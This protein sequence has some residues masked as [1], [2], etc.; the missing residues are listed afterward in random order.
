MTVT[1]F[2]PFLRE[3]SFD[4]LFLPGFSNVMSLSHKNVARS[5]S[6]FSSS[7]PYALINKMNVKIAAD[8]PGYDYMLKPRSLHE[9]SRDELDLRK[10]LNVLRE[11]TK[12]AL[13][14]AWGE[15]TEKEDRIMTLERQIQDLLKREASYKQHL[16]EASQQAR[17]GSCQS[18]ARSSSVSRSIAERPRANSVN[19]TGMLDK[20]LEKPSKQRRPSG[21]GSV[22]GWS[23]GT[24]LR[25]YI[26]GKKGNTKM[27]KN[28][29]TQHL[30]VL[31]KQKRVELQEY[32]MKLQNKDTAIR[33]LEQAN[34]RHQHSIRSLQL[35]LEQANLKHQQTVLSLQMELER[36]KQTAIE[37]ERGLHRKLDAKRDALAQNVKDLQSCQNYVNELT[38]ELEKVYG[39]DVNKRRPSSGSTVASSQKS[40][41][42][43]NSRAP[44]VDRNSGR[45]DKS[46]HL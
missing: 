13:Q 8:K 1:D 31:E 25:D 44:S 37:R 39:K 27:A 35:E 10:E 9:F 34:Q 14:Q 28:E 43:S 42:R 15:N 16:G 40:S 5:V 17:R 4:E 18:V 32:E 29:M 24:E 23:V 3:P 19:S 41:T 33:N 2:F 11:S 30:A 6:V 38:R 45:S 7:T 22:T 12:H 36:V 46:H 26:S 20:F 21:S